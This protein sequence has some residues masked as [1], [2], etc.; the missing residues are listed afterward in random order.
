[1]KF[2]PLPIRILAGLTL[3]LHGLPKI[4]DISGVQSFFPNIG[5]PPELAIPV[6][7]LEVIGGLAILFGILTRIASGLFIIEMIGAVLVAK[8]SKGFVGGYELELLIVAICISLFI[9]GPGRISIEY[10]VLKREIFP[11]GK[12]LVDS[13]RQKAAHS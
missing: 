3:M 1:M 6:A 12:Q 7:L 5:L 11:R 10:D 2:G 4:T 13:L 9:S 8:L